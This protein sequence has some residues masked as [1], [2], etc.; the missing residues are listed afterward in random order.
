MDDAM[1]DE[2]ESQTIAEEV[3]MKGVFNPPSVNNEHVLSGESYT[4]LS[5][6][7]ATLI[8]DM[9]TECVLGVDEAGRG[10]VLGPMVYGLF[11]LPLPL[12]HSLLAQTHHFDDSKALTPGVRSDL[13]STL[14]SPTT[15]LHAHC[16]WATRTMSARHITAAQLRANGAYN[17]NAQAMDATIELIQQVLDLGVNVREVYIDTIGPP[18]TYQKRLERVF[19]SLQITVAKKADSLFPCV[20]AASVCAKVT[21]D[22]ALDVLYSTYAR[23]EDQG[24]IVWGS[25]YPSDARCTNWLKGNMHPLFGWGNECRFSW[26]TA[27][28]LLES[29]GAPCRMDWPRAEEESDNMKL[30]GF[31]M[32][33]EEEKEDEMATWFGRRV[34]AEVF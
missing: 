34:A 12:H 4:H 6:V 16:G 10:P 14:C 31:L 7:P 19:P 3:P 20:S 8:A 2:S 13:M 21:R 17:L 27:K 24:A 28:E 33:P 5:A 15:D 11:Y 32:E 23:P 18:A 1:E 30:T 9:S 22:A 25:G 26:G 29:K